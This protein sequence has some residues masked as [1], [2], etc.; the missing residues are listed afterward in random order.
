MI[1]KYPIAKQPHLQQR[2]PNMYN[3]LHMALLDKAKQLNE[4]FDYLKSV[5]EQC[6]DKPKQGYKDIDREKFE[7]ALNSTID[8]LGEYSKFLEDE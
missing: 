8:Y 2:Y 5:L 1:D 6:K 4:A 7:Q 3:S